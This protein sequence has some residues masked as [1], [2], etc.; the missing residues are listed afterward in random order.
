MP[1]Y[2]FKCRYCNHITERFYAKPNNKQTVDCE[3][4][5]NGVAYRIP[6]L[7]SHNR[8]DQIVI[9]A[10]K[11]NLP[12][13]QQRHQL[14]R[15]KFHAETIKRKKAKYKLYRKAAEISPSPA[16]T[17]GPGGK[18]GGGL[19]AEIKVSE[20]DQAYLTNKATPPS[21]QHDKLTP[22]QMDE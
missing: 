10:R 21:Y 11:D 18:F 2:E 15:Q 1:V 19:M 8:M 17:I 16:M 3:I 7:F 12:I 5:S 9:Q 6:S 4:C 13:A 14:N 20:Q 22:A